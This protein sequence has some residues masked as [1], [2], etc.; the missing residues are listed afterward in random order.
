MDSTGQVTPTVTRTAVWSFTMTALRGFMANT[1]T[2]GTEPQ[3]A[4]SSN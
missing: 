2:A 4:G 1:D 3:T